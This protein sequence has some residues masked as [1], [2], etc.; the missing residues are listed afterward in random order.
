ML[1]V[2]LVGVVAAWACGRRFGR[3][4]AFGAAAFLMV[5]PPYPL[6]ATQ[7]EADTPAAV[8]ALVAL[9]LALWAFREAGSRTLAALAGVVL[10][11]ALSVKLSA[12]TVVLPFAAIA[13]MRRRLIVWSLLGAIVAA[14]VEAI[15]FRHQLGAIT[16]GVI[17]QH[18]SA[19]G[20][21]HWNRN[22]NVHKLLHFLNWHTPFAWLVLAAVLASL[23][24]AFDRRRQPS[25]ARS[26]VAVR[27]RRSRLHPRDEAAARSPPRDPGG[28]G[29]RA[30]RRRARA[31]GLTAATRE[32]AVPLLLFAAL[33]AVAGT[34]QQHRQLVRNSKP[35]PAWVHVAAN[36]LRTETRPDEVVATD[37]PI[38]A[39]YAHRRLVPDFVDTSFTRLGVGDLTSP[40]RCSPSS[41]GTTFASRPSGAR[42]GSIHRSRRAS[43]LASAIGSGTPTS[44]TTSDY[45]CDA[46]ISVVAPIHNE[47]E[48]I[49]ELHRRLTSVLTE[50]GDYEIVL[51]DD[52]STDGSWE[53]MLAL[54]P[55]DPHLRLVRLSRN[56]GHQAALTAGLEAARG[57]AVVLIDADLQDPPELIPTL[58]A[59]WREGFDVVYGLR[60]RREGE[61]LFKRSTA[62]V[63]YRLL[64]GM[65]RIEI[66]AD[67]GDF[68]LLSRRAVD[69]LAR[70]PE[71]ARFL[72]GMTSWLG[73]P[74]AGVQYERDA[75]Y[76]GETKYPTRRMIGFALDAVTS[77]STTPIRIVT[78]LGFVLVAFCAVVLSWVIYIK[79]FTNTAVAGWTSL[80]IVVLLLGGM[81]LV[82]LGIIGQYVGRI[83]EEAKQRPLFVVGETVEGGTACPQSS[84][85]RR[86]P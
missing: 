77:F 45:A 84:S 75:R 71:R 44:C 69:A 68:R 74:Q 55:G 86:K 25:L 51:V 83:F 59:K 53:H 64:R 27:T 47:A 29:R 73:F 21:S 60:T 1:V 34:Y 28:G 52:G 72:R 39:Y 48:T 49:T 42:F 32:A 14:G 67:A 15:A 10:V 43:T 30:G 70:M 40:P 9:A 6:Q 12:A 2:A 4:P 16:R 19:L 3:L 26:V 33:F 62:S 18:T 80:L 85:A 5:A 63:F 41:T 66:P 35:E 61:T 13:L 79:V 36:W 56:F 31:R 38:L 37:I 76:A 57:D 22:V 78:G 24:L 46:L 7:I 11:C 8:F 65:T 58:V 81:Q 50:L 82:S 23:W 54:A 20:S 17:S